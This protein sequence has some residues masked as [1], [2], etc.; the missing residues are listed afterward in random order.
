MFSAPAWKAAGRSLGLSSREAQIVRGLLD[1]RKESA[2]AAGLGI[3]LR[4]AH[5]HFE[6]LYHK[7]GVANHVELTLRLVAEFLAL[8]ASP[9]GRLP[10]ICPRQT[11]GRCPLR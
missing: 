9:T 4:T 11:A 8:T 3:S 5:T 7:L 2:I 6:R 1:G 10:P